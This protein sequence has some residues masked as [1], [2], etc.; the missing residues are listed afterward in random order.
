DLEAADADLQVAD[1]ELSE[2]IK[3]YRGQHMFEAAR[4]MLQYECKLLPVVDQDWTF[5]GV[6]KKAP[7]M[8]KLTELLNVA[9]QGSVITITLVR[10]DLSLSEIVHIMETESAKILGMTVE[11]PKQSD[12]TF[13]V[14]F[15]LDLQDVSRVAAALRRFDYNV[16]TNSESEILSDD[17]ESRADE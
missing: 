13:K 11:K 15:K 6:L 12:Q 7:V 9:E 10:V 1:L 2:P 5:L 16:A 3:L 8:Q 4:L 17:I 14:S